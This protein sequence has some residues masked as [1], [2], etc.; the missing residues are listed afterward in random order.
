MRPKGDTGAP[1]AEA[2]AQSWL[3]GPVI[4]LVAIGIL[5]IAMLAPRLPQAGMLGPT[6]L[7]WFGRSQEFIAAIG[8]HRFR[9]TYQQVHPGVMLMWVMGVAHAAVTRVTGPLTPPLTVRVCTI[10]Y[11]LWVTALLLVFYGALQRTLRHY[12][13]DADR[14][15]SIALLVSLMLALSPACLAMTAAVNLDAPLGLGLLITTCLVLSATRSQRPSDA[16][17]AGIA[18]GLSILTKVPAAVLTAAALIW[19]LASGLRQYRRRGARRAFAP[20]IVFG[21]ACVATVFVCWPALWVA[22]LETMLRIVVT[23]E[24]AAALQA[25]HFSEVLVDPQL[26]TGRVLE[27]M[28]WPHKPDNW[29]V[30]YGRI[31]APW[32]YYPAVLLFKTGAASLVLAAVGAALTARGRWRAGGGMLRILAAVLVFGLIYFL[33]MALA[34]KKTWRYMVPFQMFIEVWAGLA[35]VALVRA[36]AARGWGTWAAA[37]IGAALVVQS[38]Y[39]LAHAPHFFTY[40]NPLLGGRSVAEQYL[41]LYWSEGTGEAAR[42]LEA[43]ARRLPVCF[44]ADHVVY[45]H[46]AILLDPPPENCAENEFLIVSRREVLGARLP[47]LSEQY[48]R[49]RTP[50]HVVQLNGIPYL[51]IYRVAAAPV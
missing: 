10:A 33:A 38:A 39:A 49:E 36:A 18:A 3:S 21:A 16:A 5:L 27:S 2:A 43:N 29:S 35:A 19:L 23:P 6:Q 48:W 50:E 45:E 26:S 28:L 44:A 51:W 17:A 20:G 15:G 8:A 7:Q 14:A 30:V 24:Q 34:A 9:D 13:E 4:H 40:Y 11:V 1:L 47:T 46:V 12:G 41:Q 37:G 22:P 42:Y 31:S 32:Q 25:G